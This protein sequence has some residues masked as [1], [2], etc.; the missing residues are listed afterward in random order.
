[1]N[2]S[3]EDVSVI[4]VEPNALYNLTKPNKQ[5]KQKNQAKAQ[6]CVFVVRKIRAYGGCLDT[7]ER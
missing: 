6:F 2:I 4:P 1:M 5:S 3:Y 7:I